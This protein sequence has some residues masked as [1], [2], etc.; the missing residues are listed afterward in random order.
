MKKLLISKQLKSLLFLSVTLT[1]I[2]TLPT[3]ALSA[4]PQ[5]ATPETGVEEKTKKE[6]EKP[7]EVTPA[8][9]ADQVET[10]PTEKPSTPSNITPP[11]AS[12]PSHHFDVSKGFSQI[13]EKVIQTVVNVSTTQII[14]GRDKH[15]PQFAPGSPLDEL[16]K[17]FF[18]QRD[19]PRRVQSLGSGF[20]VKSAD[21]GK[22]SYAYVVTNYHVIADA[23]R[24]SIVL[25]DNTELDATVQA[26]DERTD[27]ALLKVKTDSLPP[28]KRKLQVI[29]W[30]D[31][32]K[33]Q[34]GDWCIAIG[35]PFGLGSTVTAGI[36]SNKARS[37][38]MSRGGA[39]KRSHLGEY[40]RWFIQHSAPINM[41]NSGG[42]VLDLE[43]KVIGVNTAIF[44][45]SGGN[46]GIGF[47]IPSSLVEDTVKQ[48]IEFGRTK[49][50][51][52]GVKIQA[53]TED[54]AE[55]FGFKKAKGAIVSSVVPG[56]PAAKA[57]IEPGDIVVEF[58]GKEVDNEHSPLDR[59]V[60]ETPVD[61]KVK[62]KLLRKDK[63]GNRKE[64]FVD[65]LIKEYESSSETLAV[66]VQSKKG[67]EA[68]ETK[69]VLGIKMS[70]ITPELSQRFG[71]KEDV[72]GALIVGVNGD[73]A[74]Y[75]LLVPGD[76]ITEVTP[77]EVKNPDEVI[78]A[79]EAAKAIK[80]KNITFKINRSGEVFYITIR[81]E[82]DLKP[83]PAA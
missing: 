61:K 67:S 32:N 5:S 14:E 33:V 54:M 73:S 30:G 53:I 1:G 74:A 8:P 81:N 78:K 56:G 45:P 59:I 4:K 48:L 76:I 22:E 46:V 23:K 63:E 26:I 65:V 72:T 35:N 19:Q 52:L 27:I 44:S 29:E 12:N 79:V 51:W 47:A 20:I 2:I 43:G 31:S 66:D 80:R 38:G 70:S 64:V 68:L 58:D 55:S 83:A 39:G 10:S 77:V 3:Y 21:S 36:V 42:P 11:A 49:R 71:L 18:D 13:A 62:V 69:E 25:H 82:E 50:G 9:S 15:M 41:G 75:S 34:V 57:G 17:D 7:A 40:V 60:G 16:F 24:I 37:I 6:Q 28:E